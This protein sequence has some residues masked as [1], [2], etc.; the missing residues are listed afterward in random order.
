M[1]AD[2]QVFFELANELI[3]A[4]QFDNL[5]SVLKDLNDCQNQ[6]KG[7]L[8]IRFLPNINN[9]DDLVLY[10]VKI[11][12]YL[13]KNELEDMSYVLEYMAK[14]KVIKEK[15][16]REGQCL[17]N[18]ASETFTPHIFIHVK[19]KSIKEFCYGK[20]CLRKAK[21]HK[22]KKLITLDACDRHK[23]CKKCLHRHIL[24]SIQKQIISEIRCEACLIS[25][26]E[27]TA[28]EAVNKDSSAALKLKVFTNNDL[29]KGFFKNDQNFYLEHK[30]SSQYKKICLFPG[31]PRKL[32]PIREEFFTKFECDDQFCDKCYANSTIQYIE[33]YKGVMNFDISKLVGIM[34]PNLHIRSA[35]KHLSPQQIKKII[36][37]SHDKLPEKYVDK[38][39][40][41]YKKMAPLFDKKEEEYCKKCK[42]HSD[43]LNISIICRKCFTCFR[44]G[45]EYHLTNDKCEETFLDSDILY[46]TYPVERPSTYSPEYADYI[47]CLRLYL[48]GYR[49]SKLQGIEFHRKN[50]EMHSRLPEFHFNTKYF[51]FTGKFYN[52]ESD[53]IKEFKHINSHLKINIDLNEDLNEIAAKSLPTELNIFSLFGKTEETEDDHTGESD[54]KFAVIYKCIY[55][56]KVENLYQEKN[57]KSKDLKINFENRFDLIIF[58]EEKI[59]TNPYMVIPFR[60]IHLEKVF[61]PN[62]QG[63]NP[64]PENK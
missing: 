25:I 37:R 32:K 10:Q 28:I 23:F 31:C 45:G 62:T 36:S 16:D 56:E 14:T 53:A 44:C 30:M 18:Q 13:E 26:I 27:N 47:D 12:E 64:N 35:Q 60:F 51:Y 4:Q 2:Y 20:K 43:L 15:T 34:C 39:V 21:D 29:D 63:K 54:N 11:G 38:L 52:H 50:I 49:I 7:Q 19:K 17:N 6:T 1:A 58:T 48:E 61:V 59:Y 24:K 8:K 22:I 57:Q 40:D 41:I 9:Y 46:R 5:E 55:Q 42:T 3:K 33:A